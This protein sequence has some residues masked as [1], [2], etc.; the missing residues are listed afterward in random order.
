MQQQLQKTYR[1]KEPQSS[2]AVL[3][4]YLAGAGASVRAA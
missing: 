4:T 1:P 2:V 3:L